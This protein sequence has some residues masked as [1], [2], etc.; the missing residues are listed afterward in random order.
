MKATR[1][2]KERR[3]KNTGKIILVDLSVGPNLL[4]HKKCF[5]LGQE[6]LVLWGAPL[7][8]TRKELP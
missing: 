3:K 1:N 2:V 7:C 8:E 6:N 4:D 5:V